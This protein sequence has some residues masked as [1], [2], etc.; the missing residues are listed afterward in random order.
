MLG[1]FR[2]APAPDEEC[3]EK[4]AKYFHQLGRGRARNTA[5]LWDE[6][7]VRW[8]NRVRRQHSN[9]GWSNPFNKAEFLF[10]GPEGDVQLVIRRASFLPPVFEI[11]KA[12]TVIG[13]IWMISPLR[14]R[15]RIEIRGVNEWTFVMP[16]FT[17]CFYGRS[18]AGTDIWVEMGPSEGA[19]SILIRPGVDRVELA[20]ALAFIHRERWLYG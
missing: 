12:D 14:N 2:R 1:L 7:G 4:G 17:I 10:G 15:Y 19:W 8:R 13:R 5:E 9:W 20:A 18:G 6:N 3:I 11:I 16:L